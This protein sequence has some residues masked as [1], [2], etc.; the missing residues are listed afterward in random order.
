MSAGASAGAWLRDLIHR[1][2][3]IVIGEDQDYLLEARLL[4]IAASVALTSIGDLVTK[5]RADEHSELCQRVVEAMATHETSFFRDGHPFESLAVDVLPEL[6]R[7]RAGS[8]SLRIWCA[9]AST[10]QEPYSIA[11]L[12]G[13]ASRSSRAG[14]STSVPRI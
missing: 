5:L 9:A 8:R 2:T 4:P 6:I 1:R 12:I 13:G 14:T 3:A 7:S 11:M 10:G